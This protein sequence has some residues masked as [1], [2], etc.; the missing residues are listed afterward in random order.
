[1]GVAALTVA[2]G[3]R[4]VFLDRDGVLIRAAVRDGLPFPIED[5]EEVE[6]LPGV[7][8]ACA[9]LRRAGLLL[10]VFTNQP[11]VAR[12]TTTKATVEAINAALRRQVELDDVS[13]CFHDDGDGCDCRKP[14]PG[15]LL[16]A[17]ARWDVA[18]T[19]SVVVGDR[20]RDI[21]A[22]RRAGCHTVF[23][24][25]GYRERQ[26]AEPDLV[27]SSLAEALPWILATCTSTR[28]G[29]GT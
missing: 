14:A 28:L 26:P 7:R 5:P 19:Q 6:V 23:V 15:M 17:A 1:M 29:V 4:A 20:W 24:D 9:A 12:G 21:E 18:L 16:R 10:V 11:D 27:A 25:H 2:S 22:G 8:A 3:R 13:V